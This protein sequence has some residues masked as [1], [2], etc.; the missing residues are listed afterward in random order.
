MALKYATSAI[1][2]TDPLVTSTLHVAVVRVH[3]IQR[4][5]SPIASAERAFTKA[6]ARVAFYC[7]RS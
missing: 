2:V 6:I 3:S 5:P 4:R 1:A 7:A